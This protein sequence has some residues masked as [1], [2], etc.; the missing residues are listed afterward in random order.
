MRH[1]IVATLVFFAGYLVGTLEWPTHAQVIQGYD[2]QG[3]SFQYFP[4][5]PGGGVGQWFDNHGNSGQVYTPAPLTPLP[6]LRSPC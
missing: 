4:P 1:V 3:N 2:N 5:P 6:G